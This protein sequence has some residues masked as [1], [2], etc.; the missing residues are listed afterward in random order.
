VAAKRAVA[1]LVANPELTPAE[2]DACRIRWRFDW[3]RVGWERTAYDHPDNGTAERTEK[4]RLLR[5]GRSSSWPSDG[6]PGRLGGS[7]RMLSGST[8]SP[9]RVR[10]RAGPGRP[11]HRAIEPLRAAVAANPFDNASARSLVAALAAAGHPDEAERVRVTIA[12][13]RAA[14]ALVAAI[15]P[16]PTSAGPEPAVPAVAGATPV[17]PLS[18]FPNDSTGNPGA[19]PEDVAP[20]PLTEIPVPDPV[21][22]HQSAGSTTPQHPSTREPGSWTCRPTRSRPG[23]GTRIRTRTERVH[24]ARRHPHGP[25]PGGHTRP[26]RVLEIGT[27]AGT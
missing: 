8:A 18:A 1:A 4:A 24:P 25:H 9:R 21:A 23:S 5:A 13:W 3:L 19:E 2:A 15:D 16:A 27:R 26:R 10:G 22:S 17:E 12:D 14:P 6:R 20:E 7:G 11:A